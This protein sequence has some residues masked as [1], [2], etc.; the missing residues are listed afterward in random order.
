MDKWMIL[1]QKITSRQFTIAEE[2]E[3]VPVSSD[4]AIPMD[5]W[6]EWVEATQN[7]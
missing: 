6:L 7:D 1:D 2:E 3:A 5:A 4:T